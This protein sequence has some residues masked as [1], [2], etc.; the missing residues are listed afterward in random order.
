MNEEDRV[1]IHALNKAFPDKGSSVFELLT[2]VKSFNRYMYMNPAMVAAA[3]Y[4]LDQKFYD[5][6]SPHGI[7]QDTEYIKLLD[8]LKLDHT[9]IVDATI[10]RYLRRKEPRKFT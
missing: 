5:Q 3:V 6:E 9:P 1:Y 8:R 7:F 10:L 4:I 2:I